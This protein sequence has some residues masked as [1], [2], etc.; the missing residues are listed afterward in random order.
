VQIFHVSDSPIEP[1][2]P[3]RR[4]R[5]A[6]DLMAALD[7]V[8]RALDGDQEARAALLAEDGR[9]R[10]QFRNDPGMQLAF[11]EAV[12]ERVRV[13][14]APSLPGR[15]ASVF[16]WPTVELARDFRERFRRQGIIHCCRLVDGEV[17]A[18]DASLVAV[19]MD[20]TAPFDDEI[21]AIERRA[22]QYWTMDGAGDWPELL[23]RG[24]VLV[25]ETQPPDA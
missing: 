9:L 17:L 16:A 3:L 6:D 19:G 21:R 10:A 13:Q 24:T 5:L 2:Q 22:E 12:F 23:V 1:G 11:V 8:Q 18:R 4:Y 15:F 7:L 25:V 20:Q 14:V